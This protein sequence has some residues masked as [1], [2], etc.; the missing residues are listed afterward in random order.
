MTSYHYR[1]LPDMCIF[2]IAVLAR[3]HQVIWHSEELFLRN[4]SGAKG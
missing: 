1:P 2:D 3:M 4:S